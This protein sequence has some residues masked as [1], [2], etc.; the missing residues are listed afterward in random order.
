VKRAE[1]EIPES[2]IFPSWKY[3]TLIELLVV[4]AIIAILAAMLLPALKNAKDLSR[5]ISCVSNQRQIGLAWQMYGEDNT[6][7]L[8]PLSIANIDPMQN[9]YWPGHLLDYLKLKKLPA[10]NLRFEKNGTVFFCPGL[11]GNSTIIY[12]ASYGMNS[13][14]VGGNDA[15]GNQGYRKHS[16]I[17]LPSAQM[18]ITDSHWSSTDLANGCYAVSGDNAGFNSYVDF[19]HNHK[20]NIAY[21][22]G[23]VEPARRGQ[24]YQSNWY[25]TVPWGWPK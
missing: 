13:Y 22:D 9:E 1:L 11:P 2:E 23:H 14:A 4:I 21:A 10:S 24:I 12:Q 19:R 3:F 20:V 16:Q 18:F 15:F 7:S 25:D 17:R 5:E 6:G 8:V